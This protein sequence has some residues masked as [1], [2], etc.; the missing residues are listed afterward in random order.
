MKNRRFKCHAQRGITLVES[1][2]TMAIL[3]ILLALAMPSYKSSIESNRR[4]VYVNQLSE[5]LAFARSEAI[6]R[7]VRVEVCPSTT[8]TSC[9]VS[10]SSDWATG[11]IV[12]VDL[13]ASTDWNAGE[14]IL[15]KHEALTL[16]ANW[17]AQDNATNG[18]YVMFKPTG[19]AKAVR[20]CMMLAS[21]IANCWGGDPS[22]SSRGGM[23]WFTGQ[24]ANVVVSDVGRVRIE[25][26]K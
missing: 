13:N 17:V 14:P 15:R 22:N 1:L 8:G 25:I 12:F 21:D 11:W 2:V 5:D 18:H 7:N 16:P 3:V 6:K 26:S 4:T 20:V 10:G 19:E 9:A 24:Y 23:Y